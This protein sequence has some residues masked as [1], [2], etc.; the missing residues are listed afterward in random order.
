[1]CQKSPIFIKRDEYTCKKAYKRNF[2]SLSHSNEFQFVKPHM[3]EAAK[4]VEKDVYVCKKTTKNTFFLSC[5]REMCPNRTMYKTKKTFQRDQRMCLTHLS[6]V[7]YD[8]EKIPYAIWELFKSH[9]D[10]SRNIIP[11]V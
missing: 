5:I 1:M 9:D 8:G 3:P 6:C 10:S 2:D 4:Q 11:C 7:K